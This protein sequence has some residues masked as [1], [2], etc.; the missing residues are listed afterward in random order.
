MTDRQKGEVLKRTIKL[1]I[2][3]NST[4]IHSGRIDE[5]EEIFR[6]GANSSLEALVGILEE[7]YPDTHEES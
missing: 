6:R 2:E 7:L 3:K 1:A 5:Y 4:A